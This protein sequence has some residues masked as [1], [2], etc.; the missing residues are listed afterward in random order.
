MGIWLGRHGAILVL[1]SH[2]CARVGDGGYSPHQFTTYTFI[3]LCFSH[4]RKP[5][6]CWVVQL[7]RLDIAAKVRDKA[8]I[9]SPQT[10]PQWSLFVLYIKMAS[11]PWSRTS[12]IL[13]KPIR[14]WWQTA[15]QF[16][17][18]MFDWSLGTYAGI[19]LWNPFALDGMYQMGAIL[20]LFWLIFFIQRFTERH[21]HQQLHKSL[22]GSFSR[23]FLKCQHP[24]LLE[25][26][27][28]TNVISDHVS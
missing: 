16:S 1:G 25:F 28:G 5:V 12:N 15:E 11:E 3:C 20:K 4:A 19:E 14:S 26:A 18:A 21:W 24:D 13:F 8:I 17:T 23:H 6:N 10:R 9:F 7:A 2:Q 27:R 22:E